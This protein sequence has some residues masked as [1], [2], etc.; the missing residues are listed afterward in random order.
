MNMRSIIIAVLSLLA[1]SASAQ[2]GTDQSRWQVNARLGYSIGGTVPYGF[3]EEL[4]GV[5]SFSPKANYRIGIDIERRIDQ[6]WGIMTGLYLDR[7]GFSGDM[8]VRQYDMRVI[9]G[10]DELQ[11]SFTGNVNTDI[12]QTG[13][14]LPLMAT[15]HLGNAVRLKLGPYISYL[16]DCSFSGY[17]YDGYMRKD[18]PTG[19]RINMGNDEGTRGEF[20]GDEFDEGLRTFQ[21]GINAG[22]DWQFAR[23]WG[24]SADVSLG[25]NRAFKHDFRTITMGLYPLYA[26]FGVIYK[27][28]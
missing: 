19:P 14:T 10:G 24:A 21:W 11:G 22:C 4:R 26:T 5:N 13:L 6:R 2:T 15:L 9:Y 1:V 23:H 27:I 25:M 28:M 17:A 20:S 8:Q 7:K 16:T 18:G 3:P 12:I